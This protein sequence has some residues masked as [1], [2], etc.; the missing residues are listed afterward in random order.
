M[1]RLKRVFQAITLRNSHESQLPKIDGA[2]QKLRLMDLYILKHLEEP[3]TDR[4]LHKE[5]NLVKTRSKAAFSTIT[6]RRNELVKLGFVKNTN[7]T[8]TGPN[9]RTY[10]LWL[11][12]PEK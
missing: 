10:S 11:A 12:N 3:M 6:R 4:Q 9:K 8:V 5:Y 1:N 7:V 2:N